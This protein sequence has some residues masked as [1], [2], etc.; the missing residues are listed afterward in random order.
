MITKEL[1]R[2]IDDYHFKKTFKQFSSLGDEKNH[3]FNLKWEDRYLC[4]DDAS[5][6]M[7][8]DHHYVYHLAWATRTLKKINPKEHV[9]FGSHI[10]L[11][12]MLS[13]YYKIK[14]FEFRPPRLDLEN[15]IVLKDDLKNLSLDNNSIKSL[16]CMHVV[17]HIGLGRYGDEMDYD[18]DLKAIGELIR[19][20]DRGGNLLF[21]IPIGQPRIV[22]NAH[23]IYS[24]EQIM[25]YFTRLNL[26]EFTLIPDNHQDG[27]LIFNAP[28]SLSDAQNYG[29]GCFWFKK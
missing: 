16:S 10:Y 12:A 23:R 20:L 9:D 3:R 17:E 22:F 1:K 15:L 25:D 18:G 13:T 5:R 2:K 26:V 14:Y 8:F 27:G 21:V 29:C 11:P 4:L 24:Y 7:D 28:Q 19:I 6:N